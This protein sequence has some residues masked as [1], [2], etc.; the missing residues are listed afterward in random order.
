MLNEIAVKSNVVFMVESQHIQQLAVWLLNPG[1]TFREFAP[2]KRP[3]NPHNAASI[4]S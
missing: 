1:I 4:P 2:A 3:V